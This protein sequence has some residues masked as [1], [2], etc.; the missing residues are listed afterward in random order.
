M[1]DKRLKREHLNSL[2]KSE[3]IF[4]FF[5]HLKF[6]ISDFPFPTPIISIQSI[7]IT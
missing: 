5:S 3:G 2:E 1:H 4:V 6:A 7:H